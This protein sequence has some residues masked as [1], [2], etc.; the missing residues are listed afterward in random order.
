V[1]FKAILIMVLKCLNYVKM[2][3]PYIKQDYLVNNNGISIGIYFKK[4]PGNL[5]F[6]CI[7]SM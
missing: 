3:R 5:I 4:G 2:T 6:A 7:D 1:F